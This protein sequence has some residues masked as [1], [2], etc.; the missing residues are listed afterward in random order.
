MLLK[1]C[2]FFDA[3]SVE[4]IDSARGVFV[5]PSM[6]YGVFLPGFLYIGEGPIIK[7]VKDFNFRFP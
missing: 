6:C 5:A 4:I 7:E 1:E 2:I 3:I